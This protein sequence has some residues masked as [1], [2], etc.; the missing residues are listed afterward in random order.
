M[1]L[2][3]TEITSQS[4]SSPLYSS[5]WGFR[6]IRLIII[7][8]IINRFRYTYQWRSTTTTSW[9]GHTCLTLR[10]V[11]WWDRV[12]MSKPSKVRLILAN[13]HSRMWWEKVPKFVQ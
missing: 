10:Q 4:Q 6:I 8:I 11:T 1:S 12:G 9:R 2:E 3:D 7:I 5:G 13:N